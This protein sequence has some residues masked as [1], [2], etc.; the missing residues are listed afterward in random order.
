MIGER[1]RRFGDVRCPAAANTSI[2]GATGGRELDAAV[3]ELMGHLHTIVSDNG[4]EMTSMVILRWS[5][6]RAVERRYIAPGKRYQ[7]RFIESFNARLLDECLNE[8]SSPRWPMPEKNW[9]P[10]GT[11]TTTSGLTRAW[12]L[13]SQRRREPNQTANRFGGMPPRLLLPPH[14]TE[15]SN[16]PKALL[17]TSRSDHARRNAPLRRSGV[18]ALFKS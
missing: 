8:T 7:N 18:K 6:D 16:R 1:Y 9:K 11:A 5:K 2:A 3:F 10:G 4:T 15:A 17:I 13:K 14:P 12:P